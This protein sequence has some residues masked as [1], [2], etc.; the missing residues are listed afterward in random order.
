MYYT[1]FVQTPQEISTA[2][3]APVTAVQPTV[4]APRLQRFVN[5]F[6]TPESEELSKKAERL[7]DRWLELEKDARSDPHNLAVARHTIS[8]NREAFKT[9]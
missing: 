4:E 6:R 5:K 8:R 2:V 7:N 3:A 1:F 9:K